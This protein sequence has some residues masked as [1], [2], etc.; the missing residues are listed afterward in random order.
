MDSPID[1]T[2]FIS[3]ISILV[4]GTREE[5]L[6]LFY[7]LFEKNTSLGGG[8]PRNFGDDSTPG[9]SKEE[10]M[11]NIQSTILSMLSV[12]F[13]DP[14]IERIKADVM[15]QNEQWI[16]SALAVSILQYTLFFNSNKFQK[17]AKFVR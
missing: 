5:K 2:K 6:K 14:A 16:D 3:F 4:K 8:K 10:L 12:T 7:L 15:K 17:K 9:I 11:M 1:W 13:E